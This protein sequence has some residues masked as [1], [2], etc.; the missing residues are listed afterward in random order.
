MIGRVQKSAGR[1]RS[2]WTTQL[3]VS[4]GI[5]GLALRSPRLLDQVHDATGRLDYSRRTEEACALLSYLA[6]ERNVAAATRN[7]A[8]AALLIP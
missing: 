7:R 4:K 5:E 6:S 3:A 8:L 2:I 1:D